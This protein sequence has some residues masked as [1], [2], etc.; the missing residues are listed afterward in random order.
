[1]NDNNNVVNLVYYC[2]APDCQSQK[3]L[4]KTLEEN[5]NDHGH[6]LPKFR[7]FHQ[8]REELMQENHPLRNA[9]VDLISEEI[10]SLIDYEI[11]NLVKSFAVVAAD[12]KQ[13]IK[14][15]IVYIIMIVLYPCTSSH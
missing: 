15:Y 9:K 5:M 10:K 6:H 3:I 7:T 8:L 11:D 4:I 13:M 12:L 2:V 1:M 14:K